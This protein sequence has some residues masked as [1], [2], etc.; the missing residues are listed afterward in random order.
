MR[1]PRA[2]HWCRRE[3]VRMREGCEC[4]VASAAFECGMV[5]NAWLRVRH[6]NAGCECMVASAAIATT[7]HNVLN[8]KHKNSN[9]KISKGPSHTH[10]SHM[11]HGTAAAAAAA[12]AAARCNRKCDSVA[13]C[14]R[15][16]S[17]LTCMKAR[18]KS[19]SWSEVGTRESDSGH[20]TRPSAVAHSRC[21]VL[22]RGVVANAKALL[23]AFANSHS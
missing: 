22:S 6:S 17:Q 14:I 5:A 12:A 1:M 9:K 11:S 2:T 23:A 15:K 18:W 4:M 10:M 8:T 16:F 19:D 13:R 21:L 20:G 7:Q 3:N